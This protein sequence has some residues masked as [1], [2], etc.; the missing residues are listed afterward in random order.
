METLERDIG[1]IPSNYDTEQE[2]HG[3]ISVF[4]R[5]SITLA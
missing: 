3:Q 2:K 4:E 5:D 1:H